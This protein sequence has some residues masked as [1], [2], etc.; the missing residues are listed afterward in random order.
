MDVAA[1]VAEFHMAFNL[2]VRQLPSAEIDP[3]L[4]RLRVALL[5]EEAGEFVATSEKVIGPASPT[6]WPT[7]SMSYTAPR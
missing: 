2:P 4:A 3:G 1:A 7:S 5:E 6:R